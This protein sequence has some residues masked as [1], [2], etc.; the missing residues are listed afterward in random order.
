MFRLQILAFAVVILQFCLTQDAAALPLTPFRYEAQAQRH[1]PDDTVVWL[2]FRNG[3]YY[4]KW[5]KRYAMGLD[6]N[7]VCRNEARD[8]GYRQ[9]LLGRR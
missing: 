3:R 9:S 2:N 6:G 4:L 8:S 1:C 7:F 5:Q